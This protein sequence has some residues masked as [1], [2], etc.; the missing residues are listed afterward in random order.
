MKY[1]SGSSIYR[2]NTNCKSLVYGEMYIIKKMYFI[3]IIL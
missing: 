3:K 2:I 1:A